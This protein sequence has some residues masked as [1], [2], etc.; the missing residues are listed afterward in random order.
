VWKKLLF[1]RKDLPPPRSQAFW[2]NL[3]IATERDYV[4][5]AGEPLLCSIV[6][7]AVYWIAR[8]LAQVKWRVLDRNGVEIDSPIPALLAR[9][10]YYHDGSMLWHATVASLITHGNSYW[11]LDGGARRRPASLWW[12]P[13]ESVQAETGEVEEDGVRVRKLI[14]RYVLSTSDGKRTV[15]PEEVV[16]LR[17]GLSSDLRYG[18]SPLESLWRAIAGDHEAQTF[19]TAILR[20][21]G[22][23][24]LVIAP[25]QSAYLAPEQQALMEREFAERFTREGRGRVYIPSEP[26]EVQL[27]QH[28][29][30]KMDVSPITNLFEERICAVLGI[31]PMVL[32]LGAGTEHATYSNADQ[33]YRAAWESMMA[34]FINSLAS[35]LTAQ[36]VNRVHGAGASLVPDWDS[37]PAM[38][39]VRQEQARIFIDLLDRGVVTV[40]E[41]RRALGLPTDESQN[42]LLL[43]LN[44]TPVEGY[45][46]AQQEE[47]AGESD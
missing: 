20:N 41:A 8:N 16:H 39:R 15:P 18:A 47:A 46:D 5:D 42:I 30:A 38:A 34:P 21:L 29:L 37:I 3:P 28:D 17:Y 1:W 12:Y 45:L 6:A 40:A 11:I 43:P 32:H 4:A 10:N 7:A 13:P 19:A 9:P 44:R 23:I 22:V 27:L 35:Q 33:A 31:P 36:M 2:G 25:K 24:G 14:A 26:V